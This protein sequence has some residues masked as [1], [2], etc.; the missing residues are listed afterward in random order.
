MGSIYIKST[1]YINES[2]LRT[3]TFTGD[4]TLCRIVRIKTDLHRGISYLATPHMIKAISELVGL[5]TRVDATG[6]AAGPG[7]NRTD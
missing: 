6:D 4:S 1:S 3:W 2:G 7:T 5:V